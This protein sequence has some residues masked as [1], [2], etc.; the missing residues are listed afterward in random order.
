MSY[1]ID[2]NQLELTYKIYSSSHGH[3]LNHALFF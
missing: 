1:R 2:S 3:D